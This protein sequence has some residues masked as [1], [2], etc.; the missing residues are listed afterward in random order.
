V[1]HRVRTS[2]RRGLSE[3]ARWAALLAGGLPVLA[4]PAPNLELLAWVGL[5]PGLLLM[6]TAPAR[7]EAAVRGWWFGTGYLLAA[8]Y[9]LIPNL[10]PGLLLVT[11]VIG[12]LWAGVGLAAWVTMAGRVTAGR[13]AA[14]LVLV[15]SAWLTTEYLRSWQGFGGPWAVLGVSQWQ[16]P[17]VLALAAVGGVWL[18]TFAL[19]MA[20][21]GI[22]IAVRARSPSRSPRPARPPGR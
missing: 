11:L 14:A 17:A 5:T 15:P 18:V 20:N 9:W 16:H 1:L 10:G 21:T 7:R 13:A 2:A 12:A 3:P 6:V 22:V 8:M 4:F 19:V